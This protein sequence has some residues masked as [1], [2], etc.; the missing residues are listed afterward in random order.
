MN[1]MS[2]ARPPMSAPPPPPLAR[3]LLTARSAGMRQ[4]IEDLD[5]IAGSDAP[6]VV[7]GESGTGKELV[8]RALHEGSPRAGQPLVPV[9]CAAIPD[10]M[11]EE[12]LFGH[13]RGA[14][15]G[16]HQRRAGRFEA[17]DHGT[18]FLDEVGE[19]PLSAQ[20]K[21]LR[22]LQ[23][24]TFQPLGTNHVVHVDVRVISATHRD[25][26]GLVTTG[27][28]REDLYYRLRVLELQIAPL[29]ER[30]EDVPL[31][32]G[33]FVCELAGTGPVPAVSPEAW[34]ALIAFPFPGNVREL[35]HAIEHA[36][37][38]A[39][40]GEIRLRHLPPEIRAQ[41]GR[42]I[43]TADGAVEPLSAAVRQFERRHILGALHACRG[44][45]TRAAGALGIS[46]KN[47][48]EKMR[49]LEIAAAEFGG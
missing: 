48:W 26:R 6:V 30:P 19:L 41:G 46:R 13:E 44:N 38:L 15:T 27:R 20:A 3:S 37:V 5:A 43:V 9:N 18:L 4:M 10:T 14:F 45:R 29:R 7:H 31:L 47:L 32:I 49:S 23:E 21:L 1:L 42:P 28:F 36:V 35:K 34:D 25:L 11:V 2:H 22:V 16:A 8:A 40:G 24:G 39:Q 33:R 12:E 17:A